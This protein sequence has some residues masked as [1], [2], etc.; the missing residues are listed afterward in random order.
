VLVIVGCAVGALAIFGGW[1]VENTALELLG[2]V[3]VGI[4]LSGFSRSDRRYAVGACVLGGLLFLGY[5]GL[6]HDQ[7]LEDTV[8]AMIANEPSEFRALCAEIPGLSDAE[9]DSVRA[10]F[11]NRFSG[12]DPSPS[13]VFDALIQRC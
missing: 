9:L 13:E 1:R 8:D 10:A 7:R 11:V 3:A 5:V 2:F 6:L 12:A 4:A